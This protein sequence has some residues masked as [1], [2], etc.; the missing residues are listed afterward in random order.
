MIRYSAT[1]YKSGGDVERTLTD[2]VVM[3]IAMPPMPDPNPDGSLPEGLTMIWKMEANMMLT[4]RHLLEANLTSVYALILG[5]CSDSVLEKIRGQANYDAVHRRRDP[6]GLLALIRSVMYQ[7]NSRKD[8]AM[9]IVDL[10]ANLVSQSRHMS[11]SEYL[12]KFRTKLSVIDAAGGTVSLHKGLVGEELDKRNLTRALA[13]PEEM[14]TVYAAARGRW[15]AACF[16]SRSDQHRY[17]KLVQELAND[18][19]KG[20]DCYPASLSEAYELM[21]HDERGDDNRAPPPGNSGVAF[22]TTGG[23]PATGTKAQPNNRP[24]V[25]CHRCNRTGHFSNKCQEL[26]HLNGTIL[27]TAEEEP[28]PAAV[29]ETGAALATIGVAGK[30][31]QDMYYEGFQFAINGSVV[32]GRLN[33]GV[34]CGQHKGATGKAVPSDWILL[35]NQSTVDVFSNRSLLTNI[36]KSPTSCRI[37]CNAGVVTTDLIGDL[38]GYPNPVWFHPGGI[39][40]ILSLHR[41]GQSCRIQ[42]DNHE[43]CA[44]FR[45]T[46]PDGTVRDFKPSVSGLH[47][48]DTR[49]NREVSFAIATVDDKKSKYTVRSY[50]LAVLARRIQDVIGRP[51]TRD[52]VKI[53]EGGMLQNCPVSRADIVAAE[54]IFGP[55]LGSLKGKTVRHMNDRVQSLVADV[56]YDIIKAHKDV[57]L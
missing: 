39:A 47:Y 22:N 50:Q 43:E 31:A 32:V 56:P 25:T 55:N 44:A 20:R 37:S 19:N 12:E 42:Y 35:D 46:K 30:D 16:L 57:T 53:V 49:S 2:G 27:A 14:N 21:L 45:V 6:V 5:Q 10:A 54:D 52:Y 1:K 23:A 18:F 36:R 26:K 3:T 8:R 29:V 51:S 34:L 40:N 48:C 7:Y 13:T 11:D 41:V 17:G 24:D 38:V 4:R 15:E 9:A 33:D 28:E